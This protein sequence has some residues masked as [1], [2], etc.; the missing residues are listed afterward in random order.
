MA[1]R[2]EKPVIAVLHPQGR[3][4][5]GLEALEDQAEIRCATDTGSLRKALDDARVL[6]ITDFRSD[7]LERAWEYTR[8]LEWI[9]A[10]SAGVD[11][12]LIPQVVQSPVPVTNA[13]GIFDRAIAEYVLGAML[14][15]AKDF[16]G[17]LRNQRERR[18]QHRETER[19]EGKRLLV[20]GAGSIGSTVGTLARANGLVVEGMAGRQRT[21]DPVFG[22][23]HGPDQFHTLLEK[24]DFVAV[25]A[26]LTETTHHMFDDAAFA[27]LKPGARLINVG[28]GEI[29]DT[30]ALIR[31]LDNGRLAGA[32]LDVFE[33]EPLPEDHPLW[34]NPNVM[35]SAHMAGDFIGWERALTEQ[36]IDNFKRWRRGEKLLNQVDKRRG[37]GAAREDHRHAR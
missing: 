1:S 21:G 36:F 9:H 16:K 13:R 11:K 18:W 8:S 33:E 34:T 20:A 14:L 37:Y 6:M 24:A 4:P 30:Q 35:I 7:A 5:P 12:V 19:L 2:N 15:F 32:A 28:R 31:A 27:A 3:R 23:V 26:P 22:T 17:N 10:T 29:V 25:A